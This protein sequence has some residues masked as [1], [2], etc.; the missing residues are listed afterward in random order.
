MRA[1]LITIAQQLQSSP[2]LDAETRADAVREARLLVASVLDVAPGELARSIDRTLPHPTRDRI[3]SA[4][5]RRVRGEPLAYCTGN[6]AFRHLVLAVDQRVLIPRP[7]TEVVVEEVLRLVAS[8][9]GGVAVDIGTGSG[10]IALS[11]A[12]EGAFDLVIATDVSS[13]ALAVACANVSR[14]PRGAAP[15]EFRAGADLAPLGGVIARVIVSNPP[16]IAYGEA[17]SLAASVR[18]WEPATAL[19]AAEGGMARY[20]ALLA[21]ATHYLEPD[22]WLVFEVDARRAQL[23]AERAAARGFDSVRLVR[24]LSGRERVLV[25]RNSPQASAIS[26]TQ[27]AAPSATHSASTTASTTASG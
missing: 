23:T 16:Y 4:V 17:E 18:D 10:A 26:A 11:L 21:S 6:A 8:R 2:V 14:L 24:D 9:P 25:A 27:S 5:A 22:G 20:D 1:L 7:E 15:V 3:L 19:F 12:A 13:D